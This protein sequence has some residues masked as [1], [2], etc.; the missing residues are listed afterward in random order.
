LSISGAGVTVSGSASQDESAST[1]TY[2]FGSSKGATATVN[3]GTNLTITG[4]T[5]SGASATIAAPTVTSGETLAQ[6]ATAL[7]NALATAG[8]GG[9]SVSSG[10]GKLSISGA[11][12]S[13]SGSIVQDP[14]A[15]GSTGSLTFDAS[16][17][18]VSPAGNVSG[19]TF[20]GLSDGAK[21]LNITWNLYGTAGTG[22]V[23]QTATA[24]TTS[25]TKQDGYASGQYE[26]FKID[27][28]GIVTATY[29]NGQTQD[30]GQLAIATVAN[31]QG[32]MDA[33]ST[34]YEATAASGVASVGIAGGGGR[35]SIEGS[36]LEGSNVNIS[37]EF[38]DLI[39]AQRAFEANSKAVTTFDSITQETINMIH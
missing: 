22:D 35:G 10:S 4:L 30:V 34:E 7:N 19:I 21:D 14:V 32:L 3:T 2:N 8:I 23:S 20:D 1:T 36:S 37:A 5:S 27:S 17:N 18:L 24:S 6:Y 38:S 9:V 31:E 33:G 16:G 39:V 13:T 28:S 11:S 29:S 12:Y 25:S 26:S 15:A